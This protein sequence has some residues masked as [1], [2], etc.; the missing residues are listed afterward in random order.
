MSMLFLLNIFGLLCAL[1]SCVTSSLLRNFFSAADQVHFKT[2]PRLDKENRNVL[3]LKRQAGAML[4]HG[5]SQLFAGRPGRWVLA[6]HPQA[7]TP[8]AGLGLGGCIGSRWVGERAGNSWLCTPTVRIC[9]LEQGELSFGQ[10]A[11]VYKYWWHSLR[12]YFSW[13]VNIRLLIVG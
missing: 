6:Q 11:G 4:Q 3:G 13:A 2:H 12:Y 9:L 1:F 10:L 5:Q 7:P 8:P